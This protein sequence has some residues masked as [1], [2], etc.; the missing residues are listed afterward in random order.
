MKQALSIGENDM[1]THNSRLLGREQVAHGTMSFHLDKPAGFHF[2][3]GQ[4]IDVVLHSATADA[5]SARHTFSIVSAPYEDELVFAT[6]M[7]D[8]A[9]KRALGALPVGASVAIEG[10]FG[11]LTLHNERARAAVFIAGGIG[12]TPFMSILRQAAHDRL[13]QRLVLLYSNRRPE[14]AAFLS[15]LQELERHNPNYLVVATMTLMSNATQPWTGAKG[16]IDAALV[17]RATAELAKPVYYL[18]GP[19][20]MVEA[21]R[22]TL[23]GAGLNDDDIRSEEFYGY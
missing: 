15:E 1:T 6:R 19:P 5:Q 14:D 18:A 23:N 13:P 16:L 10:P 20:G 12:I 8:S 22:Q 3:P 21:M 7:R 11:S 17:K 2:K 4:A 9:F